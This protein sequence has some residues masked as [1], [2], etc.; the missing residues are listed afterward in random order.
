M[1]T[2]DNTT[3]KAYIPAS[4]D[5]KSPCHDCKELVSTR[6]MYL[7]ADCCAGR[8]TDDDNKGKVG[9]F[10]RCFRCTHE[11]NHTTGQGKRP[12][13][14]SALTLRSMLYFD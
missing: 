2:A 5:K 1:S 3:E 12:L 4:D 10:L 14:Y 11:H 7:C 6:C 8:H 9:D 13:S